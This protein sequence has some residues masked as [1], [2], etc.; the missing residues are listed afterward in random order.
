MTAWRWGF[1][2]VGVAG[3]WTSWELLRPLLGDAGTRVRGVAPE[4]IPTEGVLEVAAA[5]GYLTR[6]GDE[7]VAL[8]WRCPHLGCKVPFCE[9]SGQ[10]ECP[11]HGSVFN[12]VG[13]YRAGPS[14]RGM[15]RYAYEVSDGFVVMDTGSVSLGSVPG[16]E[17]IDEPVRGPSCVDESES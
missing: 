12:R 8:S 9:S 16:S 3:A 14:P 2:A 5:R 4:L 1:V 11:C 10:F 6:V 13:E 17:T 7:V 15:D